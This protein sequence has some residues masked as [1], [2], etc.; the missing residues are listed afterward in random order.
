MLPRED[1]DVID[2]HAFLYVE[3]ASQKPIILGPRGARIKQI[4]TVARAQIEQ[5][6]GLR[7]YLH[8]HV[9]VLSEWQRDPKKLS[10]LGF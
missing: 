7:I 10:R 5:R 6:L 4:G 3:R 2:V 8:L 9:S 1:S